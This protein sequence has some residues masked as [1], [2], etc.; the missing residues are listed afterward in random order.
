MSI[1][2]AAGS[3]QVVPLPGASTTQFFIAPATPNSGYCALQLPPP[4]SHTIGQVPWPSPLR[5]PQTF[6]HPEIYFTQAPPC[7][8]NNTT[9]PSSHH[10]DKPVLTDSSLLRQQQIDDSP[11]SSIAAPRIKRVKKEPKLSGC[12]RNED[13][14]VSGDNNKSHPYSINALIDIPSLNK[15]SRTSSLS[16]SLSSFRFGGSLSQIWATSLSSLSGKL[17][18]MKS[19]G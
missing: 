7:L 17:N 14:L 4:G 6:N 13:I 3:H 8:L 5:P 12:K 1:N 19:T 15:S 9:T 16:S 18:N 2:K 10:D 11:P